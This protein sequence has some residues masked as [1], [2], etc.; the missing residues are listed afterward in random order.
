MSKSGTSPPLEALSEVGPKAAG[1]LSR[2]PGWPALLDLSPRFAPRRS[3]RKLTSAGK[4]RQSSRTWGQLEA[5]RWK[6]AK[7]KED[8]RGVGWNHLMS[9]DCLPA[10]AQ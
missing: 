6:I 9:W 8:E 7:R 2:A 10:A 3:L 5:V 1:W 4:I